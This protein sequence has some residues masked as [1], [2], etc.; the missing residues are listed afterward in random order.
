MK[1]QRPP[2]DSAKSIDHNS[3]K[4]QQA[5]QM[6][7]QDGGRDARYLLNLQKKIM[8]GM[9]N[10]PYTMVVKLADML[11][12]EARI[13]RRTESKFRSATTKGGD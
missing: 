4:W 2:A 13:C 9:K 6:L 5:M 11:E 10:L 12:A 8:W 3:W 1:K 7:Q